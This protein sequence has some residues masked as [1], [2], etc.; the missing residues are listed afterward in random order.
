MTLREASAVL[1]IIGSAVVG[2]IE[3][4]QVPLFDILSGTE[5]TN[6]TNIK[7]K[8][9]CTTAEPIAE[10]CARAMKEIGVIIFPLPGPG[11]FSDEN[12]LMYQTEDNRLVKLPVRC[13]PAPS[14]LVKR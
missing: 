1:L 8:K 2:P 6:C 10:T 13:I 11:I 9:Q 12:Y 4:R 7:T 3:V 5:I 14:G